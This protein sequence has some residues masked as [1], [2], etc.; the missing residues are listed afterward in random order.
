MIS[1]FSFVL[2]SI[3][4]NNLNLEKYEY[5]HSIS[6]IIYLYLTYPSCKTTNKSMFFFNQTLNVFFYHFF[7]CKWI[8]ISSNQIYNLIIIGLFL[9]TCDWATPL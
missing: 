8:V 9:C 1:S 3:E 7:L 2:Y 6:S 5:P 4:N